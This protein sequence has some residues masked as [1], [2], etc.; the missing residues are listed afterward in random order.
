MLFRSS[1]PEPGADRAFRDPLVVGVSEGRTSTIPY[2][3]AVNRYGLVTVRL[4]VVVPVGYPAD[5]AL[6]ATAEL[7]Y[8]GLGITSG[9]ARQCLRVLVSWS[10]DP[11]PADLGHQGW[12]NIML[13]PESTADPAYSANGWWQNPELVAGDWHVLLLAYACW[14][15]R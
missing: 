3:R 13:S 2:S 4:I 11:V 12:N 10:E 1:V 9:A 14:W 5:D 15:G 7:H 6:S 8:Q